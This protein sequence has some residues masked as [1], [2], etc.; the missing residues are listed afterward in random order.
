VGV[1][2][3]L[4]HG[5]VAQERLERPVPEDVVRDLAGDLPAFL[6]GE[7]RAVES[8]LLSVVSELKS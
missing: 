4:G 7:R 8:K 3:D 2:H 6:A 5:V 1:D